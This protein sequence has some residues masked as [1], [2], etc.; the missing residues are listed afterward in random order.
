MAMAVVRTVNWKLSVS[1]DEADR[2][3]RDALVSLGMELGSQDGA[4]RAT[5]QRSMKRNRWA[6]QISIDLQPMQQGTMAL[7]RI[8]MPGGNKH[9]QILKEVATAVGQEA[10][11]AAEPNAVD[12]LPGLVTGRVGGKVLDEIRKSCRPGET[13]E[14]IVG[15]GAAGGLVAFRDRCMIVKKGALTGLMTGSTG[16]GRVATFMYSDIT[17]IEYNSG[18][19]NGVLEILTPSYQG[20]ANKDFWRGATK[21]RNADSNDPWTLSNTLPLSKPLYEQARPQIDRMRQLIAE[22]KHPSPA[23]VTNGASG[24]D[25]TEQLTRLTELH[26][27]GALDAEE[28]RQAKQALISRS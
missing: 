28:F 4:I 25:L 6:S 18:W 16:G 20:S 17:G 1:P 11:Q 10:F 3:I 26:R 8:E 5:S 12:P 2:R 14:F 24:P 9:M 23:A 7:C 13:P 27:T 19:V 15:E 22:I 21:A